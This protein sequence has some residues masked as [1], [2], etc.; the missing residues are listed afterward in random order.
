MPVS[1]W[2]QRLETSIAAVPMWLWLVP[3]II[4]G[5]VL[6]GAALWWVWW[7]VPKQQAM[8]SFGEGKVDRKELYPIYFGTVGFPLG[9][10]VCR[11]HLAIFVRTRLFF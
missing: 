11:S 10:G 7:R 3:T 6:A 8:R 9:R 4:A 5:A 1:E 2:W